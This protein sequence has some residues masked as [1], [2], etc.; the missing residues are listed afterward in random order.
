MRGL[1]AALRFLTV[2][3]LPGKVGTSAAELAGSAPWFPVVGLLIGAAAAGFAEGV[4]LGAP[5]LVAAV[6]VVIALGAVS[7]GLHLDGLADSA[8]GLL[9]SRNRERMLEIMKD[10]HLGTMGVLALLAV[11][12]LK[13]A[14]LASLPPERVWVAALL[15]P[16]AGR[17]TMTMLMGLLP[18][19]RPEGGLGGLFPLGRSPWLALG[20]LGALLVVGGAVGREMG[21]A[22]A[23][24]A[25]ALALLFGARVQRALGGMTGDTLGATCEL[26]EL[27]AV[28]TVALWPVG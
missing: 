21:L 23:V 25:A 17:S 9:S 3:P 28:L 6:L 7:K 15:M 1:L 19:A 10:S 26:G 5:P 27:A 8:D 4:Y 20:A 18:Y 14:A 11:L 24:V 2:L 22:V 12:G 16:V 13:V